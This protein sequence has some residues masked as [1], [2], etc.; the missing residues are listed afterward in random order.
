MDSQPDNFQR[1]TFGRT[2][3]KVGRLG[4]SSSYGIS[5]EAL[6]RAFEQ[7]VNYIYWGSRRRASFGEGLKRLKPKRD[8]FLLVIQSYARIA[9]MLPWSLERALKTL[10]Y[11]H[12]DVLLLGLWNKPVP[13]KIMDAARELKRRGLTRF[14]AI[15]THHRTLVP[16]FAIDDDIDIVHF[17]YNAVHPGAERDIF[18]LLLS[19]RPGTVSYTATNW[20]Q[21]IGKPRWPPLITGAFPIPKGEPTPTAADCYR[22]VLSRPEVDVCMT[23]PAN[24]AQMDEALE[25]LRRGPMTEEELAWM[26]RVGR[27]VL[28]K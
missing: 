14:L 9:G 8:K 20:G 6:E 13:R 4:I 17:R 15:S 23:G 16:K 24:A 7:G 18:P 12:A 5:G 2:G 26:R 21:L 1:K 28:G 27:A 11:Y 3:E 25:A 22:F 10:G 19:K